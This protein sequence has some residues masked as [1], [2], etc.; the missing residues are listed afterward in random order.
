MFTKSSLWPSVKSQIH[1]VCLVLLHMVQRHC[2]ISVLYSI[3]RHQFQ[4]R[5]F[6]FLPAT[7]T[8]AVDDN[9]RD[10]PQ[11]T[12]RTQRTRGD[13][14]LTQ[15]WNLWN[16]NALSTFL[17]YRR[18]GRRTGLNAYSDPERHDLT[19]VGHRTT[20]RPKIAWYEERDAKSCASAQVHLNLGMPK[21]RA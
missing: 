7:S 14:V 9:A 10:G 17:P 11:M 13:S 2:P 20:V 5:D 4:A 6:S 21:D 16:F 15:I 3:F 8:A 1:E 19:D 12:Q 18:L